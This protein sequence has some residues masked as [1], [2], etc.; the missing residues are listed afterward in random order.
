MTQE[1]S[2]EFGQERGD[3]V[4][5]DSKLYDAA[6]RSGVSSM[7]TVNGTTTEEFQASRDSSLGSRIF[8]GQTDAD[9]RLAQAKRR[10]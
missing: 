4:R 6:L 8:L 9:I 5:L 2:T 10:K 3:L 1:D 7:R